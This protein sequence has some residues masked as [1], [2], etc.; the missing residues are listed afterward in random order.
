MCGISG[1]I[2]EGT[3]VKNALFLMQNA[4]IKRGPDDKGDHISSFN[5]DL[6][7]GFAHTRLSIIDLSSS[8]RQPLY[9]EDNTLC[10]VCNGEIYNYR[11]IRKELIE[12][13]HKFSSDS[14]SEVI[15]HLYEEKGESLLDDLRGMYAFALY[16]KRQ[17][18]VFF[19]RDRMGI[20]PLYY[21]KTGSFFLFA[22]EVKSIIAS[23]LIPKRIDQESVG[24]YLRLGY[25]PSP[26]TIYEG[27]YSLNPG[28]CAV[29]DE[30][31]SLDAREYYSAARSGC[32][33]KYKNID[34]KGAASLL[35]E[36]LEDSIGKHLLSDIPVGIF[37]SGG[38][39][40]SAI[41]SLASRVCSSK[42][43]TISVI[44]PGTDYDESVYAGLVAERFGTGHTEIDIPERDLKVHIDSF[45]KVMDQPTVDGLNTYLV[46]WAAKQA[47]LR[48]CL[49][50]LGSDELFGGYSSFKQIPKIYNF[51][52][53]PGLAG[54]S[55]VL[56]SLVG[57][58]RYSNKF[59]RIADMSGAP[60]LE[61]IYFKYRGIFSNKEAAKL[62]KREVTELTECI[63]DFGFS[64][65]VSVLNRISLLELSY[66]MAN[67][68]LR[69]SDVFGMCHP[70]E[71]RVPFLDH[72][73]IELLNGLPRGHRFKNTP[74]KGL[75]I[76]AVGD[77]PDEVY[78]RPKKGF[79][80]PFDRWM[81]AILKDE[82]EDLLLKNNFF[83]NNFV[84]TLFNNYSTGRLHPSRIWSLFVLRKWMLLNS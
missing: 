73:I 46:S 34:F 5:N 2:A 75:L 50:G 19:A 6:A 32:A 30:D 78:R 15:L 37:L 60:T 52:K 65:Q 31:M 40:S 28:C 76:K 18:R 20:K 12:K 11:E 64:N 35:K 38:I 72:K 56:F 57:R 10:L 17:R 39:D 71:I 9:N 66:Y 70:V 16:D 63:C 36:T 53:N 25:V 58:V 48:V 83:D 27:V 67:Q 4:L 61:N 42:L 69:D 33:D 74:N 21:C 23:G 44:F 26:R 84:N 1:I 22:S 79:A 3:V 49:S 29:I 54:L 51:L 80:L 68:L 45:F 24:F 59:N 7:I 13:G 62:L 41:V 81:K 55:K 82:I 43:K 47:G 77:L 14:D 8:G